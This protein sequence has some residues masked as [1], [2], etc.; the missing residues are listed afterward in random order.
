MKSTWHVAGSRRQLV[1]CDGG[2]TLLLPGACPSWS[3]SPESG[4]AMAGIW[5][6]HALPAPGHLLHAGRRLPL[7]RCPGS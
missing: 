5:G 2:L 3:Q 1:P 7:S 4:V 6:A